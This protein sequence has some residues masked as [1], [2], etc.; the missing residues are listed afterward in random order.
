MRESVKPRVR[1]TE[2]QRDREITNTDSIFQLSACYPTSPPALYL[3]REKASDT[4]K[5]RDTE[6]ERQTERQTER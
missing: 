2:R 6:Q 1:E 4:D 3:T 5:A